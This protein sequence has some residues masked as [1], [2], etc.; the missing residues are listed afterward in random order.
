MAI[1]TI[2]LATY[3]SPELLMLLLAAYGNNT[4]IAGVDGGPSA[5]FR[6]GIENQG[7]ELLQKGVR[8]SILGSPTVVY[9]ANVSAPYLRDLTGSLDTD[10]L[11][12]ATQNTGYGAGQL[13]GVDLE[14]RNEATGASVQKCFVP[15]VWI[16]EKFK[17]TGVTLSTENLA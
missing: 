11:T 4:H 8:Y 7:R 6:D 5:R 12:L 13:Y 16:Q 2:N 15:F 9:R 14:I 3:G 17:L 1:A 10:P